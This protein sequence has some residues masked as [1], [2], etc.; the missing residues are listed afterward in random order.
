MS[1]KRKQPEMSTVVYDISQGI[2]AAGFR[3][4]E[5]FDYDL[6]ITYLLLS[7]L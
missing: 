4:G 3:S 6:K 5:T 7:L 1:E 2:V